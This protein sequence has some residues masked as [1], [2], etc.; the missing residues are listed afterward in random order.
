MAKFGK[1][2]RQQQIKEW[3]K[4]YINYKS[5][6][7]FIKDKRKLGS[8]IDIRDEVIKNFK[9]QL[10]KELKKFYIFFINQEREL[11]LQINKR[12]HYRSNYSL[13]NLEEII[14]EYNELLNIQNLC[15]NLSFYVN[16]NIKS[17]YKILKKFDH[18]LLSLKSD[19]SREYIIEQFGMKNSDLLYI[20]QF[21]MIDEVNV[22]IEDLKKELEHSYNLFI[23]GNYNLKNKKD[24][25]DDSLINAKVIDDNTIKKYNFNEKKTNLQILLDK[26]EIKYQD[27]L[28]QYRIWNRYFELYEYKQDSTIINKTLNLNKGTFHKIINKINIMM[29]ES[30]ERNILISLIQTC[31]M[32]ICYSYIFPLMLTLTSH[33]YTNNKTNI[34]FLILGMTPFGGLL[35][36]FFIK[37]LIYKTYKT[38][39]LISSILA[40]IGNLL[41]IIFYNNIFC[42]C[43]SRLIFGFSLN[44]SV[45]RKYLIEFIPKKKIQ[46]Y[47]IYFKILSIL[48]LSFGFFLTFFC[49]L[50]TKN[51]KYCFLIP[52]FILLFLSILIFIFIYF[53]YSEPVDKQFHVY[54]EGLDPTKAVSR[55]EI[56]SIDEYLTN[57]E[58]EK[59]DELN[60]KLSLF[61]DENNFNDTN[62][63]SNTIEDIINK[64]IEKNSILFKGFLLILFY[65]FIVRYQIFS[66]ISA[67]PIFTN[68][69]YNNNK[70]LVIRYTSLL[71]FLAYFFFIGI[72]VFNLF[73]VSVKIEKI[74]YILIL[75]FI[76]TISEI[77]IVFLCE[78]YLFPFYAFF[79]IF[80]F[81]ILF[82]CEDEM[83]YFFAKTI[84]YKFECLNIKGITFIHIM[85]YLGEMFGCFFGLI[86]FLI[87]AKRE[88]LMVQYNIIFVL[89]I[90][91]F[92]EYYFLKY[93][94]D[95]KDKSIRRIIFKKNERKIQRM[96]F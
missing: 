45:N 85:V 78:K 41:I 90:I 60:F 7:Q 18:K 69:V 58:S 13:Y 49:S 23:E 63:L 15:F 24:T 54:A 52:T 76:L 22:V 8:L 40:I 72:F 83:F 66:F 73:Y 57:F 89:L 53:F 33:I 30:N 67:T 2:Y 12:L 77:F 9:E 38:P 93:S 55:G 31:F 29:S 37:F 11:Y 39:M 86:S 4:E 32:N 34:Y 26:T 65:V 91:C 16:M 42:L 71:F 14:N 92:L 62:L 79:L 25:K 36:M 96:E 48:G 1:K 95:L 56:I 50:L 28:L 35:S 87:S 20:F 59:L 3:E 80:I 44:N 64:E 17:I 46:I 81:N 47:L 43:L 75:S 82:I 21:K 84:P 10:D 70:L 27:T 88:K 74:K 94:N 51:L 19:L 5:L 61:N 68:S 6:K